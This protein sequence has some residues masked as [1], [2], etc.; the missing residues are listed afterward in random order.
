LRIG[1]AVSDFTWPEGPPS[2]GR[3]FGR[4]ATDAEQ[5][6]MDALRHKL[7]VLREHCAAVGRPYEEIEKTSYG[8]LTG[9]ESAEQLVERF[10]RLAEAG[11]DHAIVEPPNERRESSLER[12]AEA[13]PAVTGLTP[14]GR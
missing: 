4:I 7:E 6:G 12:L 1:M 5:A 13:V 8:Q 9:T 3:T 2:I 10:G 14:A 11:I